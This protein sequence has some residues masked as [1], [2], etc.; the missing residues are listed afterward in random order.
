MLQVGQTIQ[1]EYNGKNRFVKVEKVTKN[2]SPLL[3]DWIPQVVTG[4]DYTANAP[5]GGY[6][7][8]SYHK[9]LDVVK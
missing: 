1:F 7:S 3:Q 2:W 9:M 6:R 4:W 5:V 8:F